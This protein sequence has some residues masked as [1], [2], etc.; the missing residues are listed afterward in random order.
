MPKSFTIKITPSYT[1]HSSKSFAL[2]KIPKFVLLLPLHHYTPTLLFACQSPSALAKSTNP[3]ELLFTL[4][5]DLY[6]VRNEC[7]FAH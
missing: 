2:F 1:T 7:A 4:I 3:Y 6:N 5:I